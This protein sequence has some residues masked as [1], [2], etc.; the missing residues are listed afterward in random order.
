MSQH[1][2]IRLHLNKGFIFHFNSTTFDLRV[3]TKRHKY[4]IISSMEFLTVI[5]CEK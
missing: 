5:R 1:I 4:T 2:L 3:N